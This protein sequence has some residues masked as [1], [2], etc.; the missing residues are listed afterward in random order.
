MKERQT[1]EYR[2][3]G[4]IQAMELR[5]DCGLC[6]TYRFLDGGLPGPKINVH[7]ESLKNSNR[8][9]AANVNC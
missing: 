3:L 2:V 5:P 7:L 6:H 8:P 1:D 4:L 9:V